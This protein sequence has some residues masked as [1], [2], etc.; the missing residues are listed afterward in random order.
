MSLFFSMLP[1]YL[2]GNFHCMGMCGPLV[3]MIGAHHSR[4]W[5][6]LGRLLSFTLAGLFAGAAG[7]ILNQSL[8]TY[9]LS[10][11]TSFFFGSLIL[12]AALY[13]WNNRSIPGIEWV[14]RRLGGVSKSLSLLMLR[15]ESWPAF[16]F[17]FFTVFLPCGQTAIVFAACALYGDLWVGALNGFA[18]ALLT[19]PSLFMAMQ[20]RRLFP[21]THRYYN[22]IMAG[23]AFFVGLLAL[24]RGFAEIGVI[25]HLVLSEAYHIVIY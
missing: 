7:A 11:V 19:S 23:C 15:D 12:I 13:S 20:A 22:K 21:L 2:L 5:Y 17:G 10:A 1:F 6:F 9:H 8:Q 25:P 18:F 3:M 14:G 24:C 16:L 4:Y